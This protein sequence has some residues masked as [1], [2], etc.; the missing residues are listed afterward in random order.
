MNAQSVKDFFLAYPAL[1]ECFETADGVLHPNESE[2]N[3]W[4]ERHANKA[5]TI[6][7]NPAFSA[8]KEEVV[9]PTDAEKAVKIKHIT[10]DIKSKEKQLAKLKSNDEIDEDNMKAKLLVAQLESELATLQEELNALTIPTA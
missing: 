7:D 3:R 2:A 8:Q 10:K 4:V 6:H 9:L 5:I 1:V